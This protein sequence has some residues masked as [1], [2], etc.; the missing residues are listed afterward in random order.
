MKA[1]SRVRRNRLVLCLCAALAPSLWFGPIGHAQSA[2]PATQP[3]QPLLFVGEAGN[4]PFSFLNKDDT[5][6]GFD[7]EVLEALA[8]KLG[9][10]IR[11]QLL[12]DDE[13]GEGGS[14]GLS[15]LAK[16]EQMVRDGKADGLVGMGQAPGED[17]EAQ[18]WRL[19]GPTVEM[20][21]AI[22]IRADND[23]VHRIKDLEGTR[24]AVL[25]HDADADFF[26]QNERYTLVR[27]R[28]PYAGC[29]FV[30]DGRAMAFVAPRNVVR[31]TVRQSP[32]VTL[33][34]AGT[35]VWSIDNYGPAVSTSGNRALADQIRSALRELEADGTLAAIRQRWFDYEL[36]PPGFWDRPGT[37][38]V[39]TLVLAGLVLG[40]TGAAW[41]WSINVSVQR[42]T[43]KLHGEME[44]LRKQLAERSSE[45]PHRAH[46][47]AEPA[48]AAAPDGLSPLGLNEFIQENEQTFREAVGEVFPLSLQLGE[49][50]PP[51]LADAAEIRESVLH[52]CT[53]AR[54]AILQRRK[55]DS[56]FPPRV[57]LITRM[58]TDEEMPPAK[59]DTEQSFVAV[60]VRDNGQ[61]IPQEQV[62]KI[63][64]AGYTTKTSAAGQGLAV[65]YRTVAHHGGWIDVE[66][67]PGR[68]A[69]FSL[70]LPTVMD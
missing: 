52:L 66:S 20:D 59:R 40:M 42:A 11:V 58:A 6:V 17:A 64:E 23:W 3:A 28:K 45:P 24:V 51:V 48:Q 67:A 7:V 49:E 65:V 41:R 16:A 46:P 12:A 55:S 10:P 57:W 33:K 43:R 27:V 36:N 15:G 2:A 61:G 56:D 22:T 8:K 53:N 19:C 35:T 13:P 5:P 21:Y 31:Y 26:A 38:V 29:L 39:V 63:F 30:E 54:D 14:A 50:L 47:P 9:R 68:G 37:R 18:G 60:C 1:L 32:T 69:T 70:F 44:V 25:E 4:E 62:Q 34:F